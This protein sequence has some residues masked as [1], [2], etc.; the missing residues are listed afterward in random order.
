MKNEKLFFPTQPAVN[1]EVWIQIKSSLDHSDF[2]KRIE[3]AKG[4]KIEDLLPV[5]IE[6][7]QNYIVSYSVNGSAYQSGWVNELRQRLYM[8]GTI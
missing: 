3:D 5:E 4:L 7:E 6:N 2:I 1:N 8:N